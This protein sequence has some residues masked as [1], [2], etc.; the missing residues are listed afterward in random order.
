MDVQAFSEWLGSYSV[1]GRIRALALIYSR[2]TIQTRILF[3]PDQAV[4]KEQ[5][6]LQILHGLNE[7]HHTL[8]N[9]IVAYAGDE[10]E[11]FPI[12]ALSQQLLEIE[13][14]YRLEHF[15]TPAI[16]SVRSR[17][18]RSKNADGAGPARSSP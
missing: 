10:S 7:V 3:F 14:Q 13:S 18:P 6:A 9:W 16:E 4:G 5:R 17:D 8:A 1:S 15:L 12:S 11:A 2:L